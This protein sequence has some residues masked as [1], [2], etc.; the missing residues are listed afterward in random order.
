[1]GGGGKNHNTTAMR[2]LLFLL[3][4][5][6]LFGACRPTRPTDGST[7]PNDTRDRL[8][9]AEAAQLE[10]IVTTALR[11]SAALHHAELP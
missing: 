8:S 10:T 3:L 11:D 5:G 4:V 2:N 7:E 1:L 9:R 6:G